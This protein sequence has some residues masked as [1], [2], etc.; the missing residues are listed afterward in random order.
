M[1]RNQQQA[2]LLDA[3]KQFSEN[4]PVSFHVPGHKN[5]EIF[6]AYAREFYHSILALD[7]TELP[8]LDDLH[9]AQGV[10]KEAEELAADFFGADYTHFLVGGS[11]AGNLAMILAVCSAGEKIIVQRNCHKSV[12]N[13]LELSGARP[14]LIA[15]DFDES[16][17]RYTA[18]GFDTLKSALKQHPDA[19]A[20]IFTYPDYFGKTFAIREMI[21]LAHEYNVPVL[22]DEAH[23]V[24]FSLDKHFPQSALALGADVVVQSA[25]KM[26]PAMTMGS[27]LHVT[28]GIISNE[29][30]SHYL[31]MIQSSSPS[32]PIMG[33]LDAAR[34]FLAKLTP[35]DLKKIR[36][37]VHQVRSVMQSN[38][39]WDMLWAEDL[40]KLTLHTR[41]GI[42]G[43]EL[44]RLFEKEGVYP[45]FASHS[46]VLFIHGLA[47][48]EKMNQL[49][50]AVIRVKE[51]LKIKQNHAIIEMKKLFTDNIQEL[52]MPYNQLQQQITKQIPLNQSSGYIAAEAFTPYPP[53]IPYILKGERINGSHISIIN[54]L[55]KQGAII[56]HRNL[57]DGITVFD[58]GDQ[59]M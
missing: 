17:D 40:L 2:P 34:F 47:P 53:G 51:Q 49:Q 45:E 19:K 36:D 14:I 56:Q 55:I 29:R 7:M 13:G 54:Q 50:R 3:L 5:G 25:H 37:S 39:L 22:A 44:A 46:Q 32:Y 59:Q 9:S 1:K 43:Y 52:A 57:T 30:I 16:V 28:S 10:I 15:P 33:S 26:A 4:N 11:S 8:G 58:K 20:V 35:V 21:E 41:H 6:P 48:F 18:P 12:F 24:H 31:Q 38:T 23:G 27:F 42:T